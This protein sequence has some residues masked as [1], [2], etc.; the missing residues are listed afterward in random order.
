MHAPAVGRLRVTTNTATLLPQDS[1][2]DSAP[3]DRALTAEPGSRVARREEEILHRPVR[4]AIRQI[5]TAAAAAVVPLALIALLTGLARWLRHLGIGLP[6]LPAIPL[7]DFDLTDLGV[8]GWVQA[9]LDSSDYVVPVT[10]AVVV[11]WLALRR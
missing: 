1:G 5:L 11:V 7:S 6:G 4:F 10:A 9:A 3:R 2:P 8:P